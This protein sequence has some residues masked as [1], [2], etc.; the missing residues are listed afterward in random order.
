MHGLDEIAISA[1][2]Y[3]FTPDQ[4]DFFNWC[5][6]RASS[7]YVLKKQTRQ[8]RIPIERARRRPHSL[9]SHAEIMRGAHKHEKWE[10]FLRGRE[11]DII[12]RNHTWREC[13]AQA[14]K[15]KGDYSQ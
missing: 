2:P 5:K 15:T 8:T 9:F 12:H 6:I 14:S 4:L 10:C 1:S 3:Y 7:M 11:E 13:E